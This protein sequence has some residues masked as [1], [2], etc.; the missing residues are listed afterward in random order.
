MFLESFR[1]TGSAVVQIILLAALGYFLVK[2]RL[3]NEEGL[4]AI[5]KLVIMAMLPM[6]IFSQLIN[7]FSFSLYPKWWAFP[8]ISILI[9]I[10]ALAV[11]GIFLKF[12]KGQE[13][14][15]QFLSLVVFQ[16]SGYLPLALVGSLLPEDKQSPMFIYIFLFLLGF[17]IV[18]FSLGVHILTFEKAKKFE[19]KSLFSSPVIA[20][21][22]SLLLI[23]LKL[24]LFI[25]EIVLKP[26]VMVG[27]CTLPLAM[28][29]VGAS[30][31]QIKLRHIDKKAMVFLAAAKLIILPVL[32]LIFLSIFKLPELIGLLVVMQL[33]MP[34]ATTLSSLVVHYEKEDLLISQG[35]FFSHIISIITIPLFLSLYFAYTM[36]K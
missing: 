4:N 27:N 18:M 6:L 21:L 25:P 17:N 19:W 28:L 1:I 30:L 16:N 33:A 12:I 26:L 20:V 14:K 22:L 35:I 23:Y 29:V 24:N 8:L 31:A 9:T 32:G 10:I 15:K 3:L 5:G 7:N 13:H 36:L 11:G 34:A 2:K